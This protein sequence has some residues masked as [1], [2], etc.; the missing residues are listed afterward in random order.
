[1]ERYRSSTAAHVW[2]FQIGMTVVIV[3]GLFLKNRAR[4]G[5]KDVSWNPPESITTVIADDMAL[6]LPVLEVLGKLNFQ[7]PFDPLHPVQRR[8]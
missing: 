3:G 2:S 4:G 6:P 1:M 7:S 5:D 8:D